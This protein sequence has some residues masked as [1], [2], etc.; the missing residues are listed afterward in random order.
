MKGEK[1]DVAKAADSRPRRRHQLQKP[2]GQ[3]GDPLTADATDAQH[4]AL[5][6]FRQLGCDVGKVWAAVDLV[7]HHHVGLLGLDQSAQRAAD[8]PLPPQQPPRARAARGAALAALGWW[9]FRHGDGGWGALV[10]ALSAA[11]FAQA[12]RIERTGRQNAFEPWLFAR[13]N[14]IVVAIPFAAFGWWNALMAVLALYAAV[15]FFL[16]QHLRHRIDRD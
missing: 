3:F 10:V 4:F 16:V 12:L 6:R 7:E 9:S 5:E 15:S 1:S 8:A 13:R 2:V 11:G 14:A